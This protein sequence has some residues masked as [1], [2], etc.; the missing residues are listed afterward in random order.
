M[1]E[2][3]MEGGY[4]IITEEGPRKVRCLTIQGL[5]CLEKSGSFLRPIR[6]LLW[7]ILLREVNVTYTMSPTLIPRMTP[8]ETQLSR[9]NLNINQGPR[10]C[11]NLVVYSW[12]SK[13]QIKGCLQLQITSLLLESLTVPKA[14]LF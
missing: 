4:A 10:M 9:E 5:L 1:Q 2:D 13:F 7:D 12:L 3:I 6:H 11:Q 14:L 8:V